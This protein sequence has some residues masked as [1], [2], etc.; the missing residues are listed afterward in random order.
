MNAVLKQFLERNVLFIIL[1]PITWV[2]HGYINNYG[3]IPQKDA[4]LLALFYC[5]VAL[6]MTGIFLLFYRNIFKA[7]LLSF[8][9]L[10][11]QFFFG[12][13]HDWLKDLFSGTIFVK[14][15]FLLP[16]IFLLIITISIYLKRSKKNFHKVTIYLN[17]LFFI[18]IIVDGF[19][20]AIRSKIAQKNINNPNLNFSS[21][22]NCPKP[23]I[24]LIVADSYPGNRQL[25][26][27]FKFNNSAFES[28]LNHRLF[29]IVDSSFSNYNFTQYSIASMLSLN[30]LEGINHI[31]SNKN[32][33]KTSR[34]AIT[35]SP[36]ISYLQSEGYD[37]FNHSIFD[38]DGQPALT[39]PTF[40][41][42]K[43]EPITRHT[44]TYRLM[45]D[46]GYH[47][48]VTL[49]IPFM[50]KRHLTA[51][52]VNNK[53]IFEATNKIIHQRTERP[54][55]VYTHLIM[56]H[57][58]FFYDSTGQEIPLE[59]LKDEFC[60]DKEAR[61]SYL[62]YTNKELLRLVD[63]ILAASKDKPVIFLI[64]DHGIRE[65]HEQFDPH[66]QF[67]NLNAVLLPDGDYDGL[68]KGMSNINVFRFFLNK[69]FKQNLPM[70]KD[71]TIMI[72]D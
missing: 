13:V 72:T 70:L 57:H 18:L 6:A 38:F 22:K 42:R 28:A 7:A 25:K 5:G 45:K 41:T 36:V 51:D 32:D 53:K 66:Y 71:S 47:F 44:F 14:Y 68:Y 29:F 50:V 31:N 1:L 35:N 9:L 49:K 23:D 19:S 34:D 10:S 16:L 8:F 69:Q 48:V 2:L 15:S 54:K 33:I 11:L 60:Y 27:L 52:L 30:Y 37:F 62:K 59:L 43:L 46:I 67:M 55:L 58:P 4:I 40:L 12:P 56:P 17:I 3:L 65:I 20:M 26:D 24:Y 21:C 64:G 39:I 63:E 61:I